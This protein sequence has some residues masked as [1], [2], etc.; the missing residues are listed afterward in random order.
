VSPECVRSTSLAVLAARW[1]PDE[2]DADARR[3]HLILR[4][5]MSLGHG[6]A[7]VPRDSQDAADRAHRRDPLR[8]SRPNH[9]IRRLRTA[10]DVATIDAPQ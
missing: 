1:Q 2:A 8:T 4:T 10:G 5:L 7:A 6:R 3:S 9:S